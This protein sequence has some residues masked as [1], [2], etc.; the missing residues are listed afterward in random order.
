M[1]VEESLWLAEKVKKILPQEPFPVLNIGSSTKTLRTVRQPH[2][3]K[4]IFDLFDE[5]KDVVHFD[6]KKE[7]GVDIIGDINDPNFVSLLKNKKFKL[8][9]CN[10][11]LMYLEDDKRVHL[12]KIMLDILE[13]KG[14]ILLSNSYIYPPSPDPVE[15]YYRERP[16]IIHSTLFPEC[17][18]ID[19]KIVETNYSFS[20]HLKRNPILIFIKILSL[21]MP[22][23][24]HREWKFMLNYY[25]NSFNKNYSAS[26]LF[27]QKK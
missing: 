11:I 8:I 18:M 16:E 17:K 4:N 21:L 9:F 24:K 3:Q 2:I 25:L 27:L 22:F 20:S 15:A 14:Y 23:R 10:N 7:E 6:M 26:C 13:D 12:A 19:N 5:N 1:L